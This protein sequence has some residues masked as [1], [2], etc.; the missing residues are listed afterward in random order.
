[1]P[2]AK[3]AEPLNVRTKLNNLLNDLKATY[4][5][6]VVRNLQ[7]DHKKW[8]EKVTFLYRE[9]GYA[10]GDSF[11][12]AY[13]FT[14]ERNISG[15]PKSNDYSAI[16][17]ELKK[18]YPDGPKFSKV[19]DLEK[20]NP[21]LV[22]SFKSM[23]NNATELFGTSLKDYLKKIGIL[24]GGSDSIED[25]VTELKKRYSGKKPPETINELI[26]DNRD[27]VNTGFGNLVAKQCGESAAKFL[28]KNGLLYKKEKT[29]EPTVSSQEDFEL[30]LKEL[31]E[32]Y[33]NTETCPCRI[34]ELEEQNPDIPIKKMNKYIRENIEDKAENFYKRNNIFKAEEWELKEYIY[35][36]IIIDGKEWN[37]I[38][39]QEDEV[40]VGDLVIIDFSWVG[41]CI[42]EVS[43]VT[44][45]LGMDA[46]Y[47]VSRTKYI[48]RNTKVN[49]IETD[50]KNICYKNGVPVKIESKPIEELF[51]IFD[52]DSKKQDNYFAGEENF[53]IEN[54]DKKFCNPVFRG[55]ENEID[56]A[57]EYLDRKGIKE[58]KL[59][60]DIE[61]VFEIRP[62]YAEDILK[63]F[64]NLKMIAFFYNFK[65]WNVKAV[66]SASGYPYV[67]S[68]SFIGGFDPK[69]DCQWFYDCSPDIKHYRESFDYIQTGEQET[70]V[71]NFPFEEEWNTVDYVFEKDGKKLVAFKEYVPPKPALINIEFFRKVISEE[72][73]EFKIGKNVPV[74]KFAPDFKKP[75]AKATFALYEKDDIK[76]VVRVTNG[77][78]EKMEEFR[79]IRK[80]CKT[81]DIPYVEFYE[82]SDDIKDK[83]V[84]D[85][86]SAVF[87]KKFEEY[88]V[89]GKECDKWVKACEHPGYCDRKVKVKFADNRSYVYGG[90]SYLKIGDIVKVDGKKAGQPGMIIAADVDGYYGSLK[91]VT[92]YIAE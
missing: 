28:Q 92:E 33:G 49:T 62:G 66:Y 60:T 3:G 59:V 79:N 46:P 58:R 45:C 63:A 5:D 52:Y 55:L 48:I 73:K 64:P 74:E 39:K 25:I 44:K 8:A 61:G 7:R 83:V 65:V 68:S 10:D 2:I 85:I 77:H 87:A 19:G 57:I 51:G 31:K 27:I 40:K 88:V 30:Y 23:A 26:N 20:A 24:Q 72:F 22:S 41:E 47:P 89:K 81:A 34:S 6:G 43:R 78:F 32:R 84:K 75:C 11:L 4:P 67:T 38:A 69:A 56:A 12:N 70:V 50:P 18:R 76:A 53:Y 90:Y 9:L 13:G 91:N 35:C 21:D 86:S 1:M 82:C 15:R 16:I 29:A 54:D 80:A 14:V 71:Y 17:E 37:Y 42:G 36:S